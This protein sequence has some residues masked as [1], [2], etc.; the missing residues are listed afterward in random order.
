MTSMNDNDVE[1]YFIDFGNKERV[2]LSW[3]KKI[4][5]PLMKPRPAAMRVSMGD[6]RSSVDESKLMAAFDEY[7]VN[8]TFRVTIL[9]GVSVHSH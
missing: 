5:S 7:I 1:V 8:N 6:F 3:L 2:N 9:E 4:P